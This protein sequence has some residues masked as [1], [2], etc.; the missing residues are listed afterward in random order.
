MQA[1]ELK[2]MCFFAYHG[3]LEQE[4]LVGN[5]YTVDLKLY[6]DLSQAM[7]S[8]DLTD[9]IN[10]AEVHASVQEEMNTPSR[11]IEHVAGRIIRRLHQDFPCI[12]RIDLRLAKKNPPMGADLEE[13][14]VTV[15][16]KQ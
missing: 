10:Y 15:S 14:A 3:V 11:L 2:G 9:T 1:I 8:D 16:S 4:R 12:T 5:H 7:L 13:A 6:L